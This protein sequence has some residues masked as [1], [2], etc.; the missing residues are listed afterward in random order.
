MIG[1]KDFINKNDN[2]SIEN[3]DE[4]QEYSEGSDEC[5]YDE[6]SVD[7]VED[8]DDYEEI[9]S[10]DEDMSSIE[11]TISESSVQESFQSVVN[12]LNRVLNSSVLYGQG[13]NIVRVSKPGGS[14]YISDVHYPNFM[15]C[16]C[17]VISHPDFSHE[18]FPMNFGEKNCDIKPLLLDFDFNYKEEPKGRIYESVLKDIVKIVDDV[19]NEN[20]NFDYALKSYVFEKP[21]ATKKKGDVFKDG[22]HLVYSEPF[23]PNQRDFIYSEVLKKFIEN[24]IF[25]NL[26]VI[27]SYEDIFDYTTINRNCWM[28]YGSTKIDDEGV[29][30]QY[31][32]TKLCE[33]GQIKNVNKNLD[34]AKYARFFSIRKYEDY[35][36]AEVKEG[37]EFIHEF[38]YKKPSKAKKTNNKEIKTE[39]LGEGEEIISTFKKVYNHSVYENER[40]NK[41][42]F[43]MSIIN[44]KRADEYDSWMRICWGLKSVHST[45]FDTFIEFSK[46]SPKFD[47]KACEKM[48]EQGKCGEGMC[49]LRTLEQFA[50][51]DNEKAYNEYVN[52]N[53]KLFKNAL[54]GTAD[55]LAEYIVPKL[56]RYIVTGNKKDRTWYVFEN[57]R[58]IRDESCID[59]INIVVQSSKEFI[60]ACNNITK[61][62][63]D[64]INENRKLVMNDVNLQIS[65]ETSDVNNA[66]NKN[67]HNTTNDYEIMTKMIKELKE[68]E[69]IAIKNVKEMTKRYIYVADKLKNVND[70]TDPIIKACGNKLHDDNLFGKRISFIDKID[71]DIDLIGFENGVYNTSTCQFREGQP[72]DYITMSTGYDYREFTM[73]HPMVKKVYEYF[74]SFQPNKE[75]SKFLIKIIANCLRGCNT[76]QKFFIF[77][78]GG[79]NGKSVLCEELLPGVFGDY[80]ATMDPSMVTKPKSSNSSASPELLEL[81]GKRVVIIS[82]PEQNEKLQ[83][84]F[85][86]KIT[87][88]DTI[89][90]RAI[91]SN[92]IINFKPQF[93]PFYICNNK[94]EIDAVDFGIWRRISQVGFKI[95]FV[96]KSEIPK[97]GLTENQRIADFT[98]NDLVHDKEFIQATMWVLLQT[99][100]TMKPGEEIIEPEEVKI[101]TQEYRNDSNLY[102]KFLDEHYVIDVDGAVKI[103]EM[104]DKFKTFIRDE[105]VKMVP[106]RNE[107]KNYLIHSKCLKIDKMK[108]GKS[109][110]DYVFGISNIGDEINEEA[111]CEE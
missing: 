55:D 5:G 59:I 13:A 82:E 62:E 4:H 28:M 10:N 46:K 71:S 42:S 86:K 111:F 51:I 88:G 57:H 24:K 26:S 104:F 78:G 90:A 100:K 80:F 110:G 52:S 74:D 15:D 8:E 54:N 60:K 96:I 44:P 6:V 9:D 95:K 40:I 73:D 31:S 65:D 63:Q 27:N 68:Q 66:M 47:Y 43:Y 19:I 38:V 11:E 91:L 35:E 36:P 87:G 48:W 12:K 3:S 64:K 93:T 85:V 67:F 2:S 39:E 83:V 109:K 81:K 107:F 69:S 30:P 102:E 92:K 61:P 84:G 23:S 75:M 25:D 53:Q 72:E 58:W 1:I 45:L 29:H 34:V 37:K 76:M 32:Y 98:V 50:M 108:S 18:K 33:N 22:F 70:V 105:Q 16:Y 99:L 101:D 21:E 17:D 97:T 94:P 77:F 14:F 89:K 79:R 49:S 7:T 41:A 20:F 103:T 56:S 106:N